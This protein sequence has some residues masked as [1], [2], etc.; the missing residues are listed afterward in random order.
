MKVEN[1][2]PEVYYK[3]SRDFSYIGRIFEV[4][5]NYMKTNADLV[6]ASLD[7]ENIKSMLLDL[8]NSTL[9]F[10][11]RHNY[12]TKDLIYL[13]SCFSDLLRKKGTMEAIK[14]AIQLLLT[15]QNIALPSDVT[16][17]E[18]DSF[19]LNIILPSE[20]TDVI[21][22]ED[23]FDYILPAGWTFTIKRGNASDIPAVISTTTVSAVTSY[24]LPDASDTTGL[25]GVYKTE[26]NTIDEP[27][28]EFT[29]VIGKSDTEE[30]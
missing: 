13:A 28:Y 14:Q 9:G 21:L 6:D 23:L 20:L 18:A 12:I 25:G 7:S 15:S 16:I 26:R 22:L 17:A 27:E 11:S 1:L 4:L 2:V 29:L 19:E 10:E 8:L 24:I 30:S 5:L 3:E